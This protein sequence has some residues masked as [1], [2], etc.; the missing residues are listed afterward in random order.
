[1]EC[2][3]LAHRRRRRMASVKSRK[4]HWQF[5]AFSTFSLQS[6][7]TEKEGPCMQTKPLSYSAIIARALNK[8]TSVVGNLMAF[9]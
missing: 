3:K 7:P 5:P 9:N 2:C 4:Q 8:E 1:M 6:L